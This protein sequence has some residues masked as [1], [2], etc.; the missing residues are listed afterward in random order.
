MHLL[1]PAPAQRRRGS[2][3]LRLAVGRY[4]HCPRGGLVTLA[5]CEACDLMQGTLGDAVL[6]VLCAYP[7][8]VPA[9]HSSHARGP[10]DEQTRA[11]AAQ[12][13]H[14]AAPAAP[15]LA[16]TP[17]GPVRCAAQPAPS[18]ALIFDDDWPDD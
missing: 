16:A 5:A 3:P 17:A 6:E 1:H 14:P 11:S 8:P 10:D 15:A 18:A 4:V 9:L 2:R 7:E 12:R 13:S